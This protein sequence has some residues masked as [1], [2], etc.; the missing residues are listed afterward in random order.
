VVWWVVVAFVWVFALIGCFA[1]GYSCCNSVGD[2]LDMDS[3]LYLFLR[4]SLFLL[5]DLLVDCFTV[6]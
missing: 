6:F 3:R 5:V 4:V 1:F 2:L